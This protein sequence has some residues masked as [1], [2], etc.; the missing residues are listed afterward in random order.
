[1][2]KGIYIYTRNFCVHAG[3]PR[4]L[5]V[6]CG[7]ENSRL[8]FVQPFLQRH[9]E[10]CFADTASFRYGKSVSNQVPLCIP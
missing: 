7:T 1:M 9:G 2:F 5:R 8:A 6:D 3:T 4:V 10:D